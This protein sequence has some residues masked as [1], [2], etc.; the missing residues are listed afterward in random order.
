[1]GNEILLSWL[2]MDNEDKKYNRISFFR[3]Q[4]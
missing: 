2:G 4:L 3:G 1:M